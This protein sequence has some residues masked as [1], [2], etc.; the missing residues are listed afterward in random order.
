MVPF[1]SCLAPVFRQNICHPK[2]FI[3][4]PPECPAE[5]FP[6]PVPQ[7]S[8]TKIIFRSAGVFLSI[9]SHVAWMSRGPNTH[10]TRGAHVC[11]LL[12]GLYVCGRRW[13][14]HAPVIFLSPPLFAAAH[15]SSNS[16]GALF[17]LKFRFHPLKNSPEF[18]DRAIKKKMDPKRACI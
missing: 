18:L 6:G 12:K 17:L 7:E 8:R 9:F 13:R 3:S 4:P 2:I 11:P 5:I 14:W 16:L 1:P 15:I 10:K